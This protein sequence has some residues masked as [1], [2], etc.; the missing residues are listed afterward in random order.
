M[1]YNKHVL[2]KYTN[3]NEHKRK[4]IRDMGKLYSSKKDPAVTGRIVKDETKKFGTVIMEYLSGDNKGQTTSIS[5]AT[6]KRWWR[7]TG[8]VDDADVGGDKSVEAESPKQEEPKKEEEF[9]T[10]VKPVSKGK[11]PIQAIDRDSKVEYLKLLAKQ[12]GVELKEKPTDKYEL[13]IFKDGTRLGHICIKFRKFVLYTRRVLIFEDAD[14]FILNDV[15]GMSKIECL[16][17]D[18]LLETLFNTLLESEE[19]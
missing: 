5:T 13:R 3:T 15:N 9:V 16:P 2:K 17:E 8:E 11:N 19:K 7:V 12:A 4:E 18:N 10:K 1:R 6:L 14:S